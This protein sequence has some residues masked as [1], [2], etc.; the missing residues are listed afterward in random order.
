[1]AETQNEYGLPTDKAEPRRTAKLL[2]RFYRTE[3]N[4]KFVQA[5]LDQLTQS[6]TVKK[7]NGYIGR[8]NAKAVTGN[9]VFIE[10]VTTDRQHYQLEPS[11]V[12]KDTLDNVTFFK[13]Y[14]DYTNTVDV[15][16]GVNKNHEKLNNQEFY[17]WNPHVSWDKLVNFQQY[18]WLPYGPSIVNIPGQQK[19]IVSTYKVI[20]VDEEDNR[21]YLFTPN[22]LTRNP[23]LKL[24]RGQTYYFEVDSL[25]EPFSIKTQRVAG[26]LFRYTN[27]V[28]NNATGSGVVAFTVP[29]NSPDVL[30]YVSENSVDTGGVF[31]IFDITENTTI[32]V[33]ADVLKKKT[34]RLANGIELSNGMKVT[35]SGEVTP[36]SYSLGAFYVEGV[37]DEI[38]L[39]PENDL[40]IITGYSETIAILFDDG[41]FD[42][43]PFSDTSAFAGQKDYITINRSNIDGNPWSRYN[44]WFH[45]DV[46]TKSA[47][48]NGLDPV[49]DQLQ[50]A[51]RPIIEFESNLKL[52][53]FGTTNKKNV[54][55]IDNYTKDIFSTVEGSLGYIV[56]N[57]PLVQGNRVL[58]T[59]DTDSLANNRIFKVDFITVHEPGKNPVRQ[60]HLVEED[61]TDSLTNETVLIRSGTL[62]QGKTYWFN[63]TTWK[64]AQEKISINQS[65]LFD[66]FDSD[67]KSIS[68]IT[69][70]TGSTFVGNK[71]FS[72]KI[73]STGVTDPVLGFK[74]SYKN[75]N[76]IGDIVFN[77]D[78]LQNSFSY[79]DGVDVVTEKTDSKFLKVIVDRITSTFDNGWTTNLIKN[80]Q[81]VVKIYKNV[82]GSTF[83]I[84]V[85]DDIGK[86]NDLEVRVYIDGK[87]LDKSKW[88]L[89][90]GEKY[91]YIDLS[92]TLAIDTVLTIK[93]FSAQD[94][95]QKG[96]Y[97]FPINLQN[98]PLNQ[99]IDTFTLG[100]AIDHVDSIIDNTSAFVGNYPGSGNLRDLA[101]LSP[102]GTKF[103]QHSGPLNLGLYH[104]TSKN[105][106]IIKAL[107]QARNEYGKFKRNFVNLATSLESVDDVKTFVD[108]ILFE[109]NKDKS[110]STPYYFSDMIGYGASTKTD[111][112][113]V[114]Y[115]IKT[116]PLTEMFS[117]D[118]LSSKA[119]NVYVNGI[120]VL[121][122][123]DYTFN[124]SGF[125]EFTNSYALQN[126]AVITVYEYESTDGCF[127]P[128]TPTSL[129]IWPKYEPKIYLDTTLITPRQVIQG[130]DGSI[131]LAYNDYR[132]NLILDIE[133][134][135]FNNIK[136]KYN[137]EIFDILD[138]I[139]GY[140]R[141]TA[142]S[143]D[144]F[145]KILAPNFYQW[146][147][148]IDRDFTKPLTYTPENLF[149]YNYKNNQSPDG[150]SLPAYWRGIYSW[151]FDTDRIHICPWES[152]GFSIEPVWWNSVY[153]TAPYTSDNFLLWNDL[154][155]GI[156]REPN[157]PVFRN[158][159]FARPTLA[160]RSPVDENGSLINPVA[161][162]IVQG[163]VNL[164]TTNDDF[165]FGDNSPVETAW[166]RSSFY[167]FSV[168]VAATLMQPNK[169]LG[170][171]LDRSR[172]VKNKNNQL[173]YKDTGLR[174]KLNDI[175]LPS[176]PSDNARI[177]TAGLVNYIVDYILSDNLKSLNEYK[178]DLEYLNNH[179]SH[180]LGG[181]TS[182]EKLNLILDSKSPSAISGVFVPK[183]NYN[184][185]LN[186]SSPTKKLNYSG[187]I[188]TKVLT[189]S[190]VGYEV[191]GYSQTQPFFYYYPWIQPGYDINVGGISESYTVWTSGQV[192]SAGNIVQ[193][194]NIYY[195]VKSNHTAQDNFDQTLYQ[196]LAVLPTIGGRTA[197]L[198][199]TWDREPNIVSYGTTY[200]TIQEVVDF[201]QGYGEYLKDQGFVFDDYNTNLKAVASWETSVKEFLFWT[202]QNWSAGTQKYKEWNQQIELKAD[203]TV[204]FNGD[205]Y[206]SIRDHV[207]TNTFQSNL[208]NKLDGLSQDGA[209]V[210]T[211]SPA[212]LGL[213][214]NVPYNVID[215]IRDSFNEY[216]I[217][218]AD[219]LKFD[220]NF[221][222]YTRENNLFSFSPRVGGT[223]IYGA[224]LFLVQK[225]HVLILDNT[226]QFND[227]IYN[228]PAGY[229][230]D[231]IK[232]SGYKTVDW[233]G[234]FDI[235]GFI[236]D[237]AKTSSWNP[238]VDY[239][240]GDIAKYKEF[241]YSAEKFLPGVEQ[242]NSEDWIKLENKPVPELL[243]NW[244]YK[245]EQ[246]TDFY[247]LES[248][249][250]DSQQQKIAQHLIGYQKRQYLENII[251]NDVSEYKFFQGMLPEKGSVNV[252]NKL[253]DVLSANDTESI[254]FN[255]EWA[256]RVGQY[257]GSD[258][259]NEIEFTLNESLFKTN[260]QAFELV[261]VAD[262]SLVDFVIR[263]TPNE[264]YVKPNNYNN[265]PWPV[266]DN[267][268]PYLRTPGFV[269][270][271]QVLLN[272]DSLDNIIGKDI[273]TFNNGDYV[274]CAFQNRSW[275]VY[276]FTKAEFFAKDISY[277]NKVLTIE[278]DRI[279]N[280][281]VGDI[282][283]IE[284]SA[285]IQGFHKIA[286]IELSI[287]TVDIEIKDWKSAFQDSAQVLFYK[288]ASQRALSIDDDFDLPKT[289]KPNE[290]IWTDDNGAGKNAV[291]QNTPVYEK[292]TLADTSAE[293]AERFGRILATNA[294]ASVLLTSTDNN[295]VYVYKRSLVS[296][297][298]WVKSQTLANSTITGFG[299]TL[300]VSPDGEWI[301]IASPTHNSGQGVVLMYSADANGNY[302]YVSTLTSPNAGNN[303]QY[304][305]KI[306]IA[307]TS[308]GYRMIVSQPAFNSS[309]GRLYS[310][311]GT[312]TDG[313]TTAW[314]LEGAVET[315]TTV[316]DN[317]GYD[318]DITPD[319]STLIVSAPAANAYSGKV[320]VYNH[321]SSLYELTQTLTSGAS[322]PERYGE[323]VSITT[324][325]NTVAVGSILYDG[326]ET[327]QGLVRLYKLSVGT[328]TAD[329]LIKNRNPESAE[330]F[331]ARVQFINNDK[332]LVIFSTLGDSITTTT[333]DAGATLFDSG[334]TRIATINKDIGRFDVY[335][336]YNT[337]F[338]F[339]ESLPLN[340][341]STDRYGFAFTAGNNTII[342]SAP[343]ATYNGIKSGLLYTY[344]KPESEYSWKQIQIQEKVVDL[345]KI[346]KV[347]LYNKKTN[348]LVTYLDV[349]DPIQGKIAGIAEQ[350]IKFKTY[351]DPATYSVGT[352]TVNVDDG[353]AWTDNQVGML[354][355]NMTK[356]K[357]L[358]SQIGDV[359]YKN[360]TWNTL[361]DTASIDIYEWVESKLTPLEWDKQ[362]DTE[363]GITL[364]ISGTSLYGNSVYSVKKRYDTIS[365]AFKNTYYFWVKNKTIIPNVID[366]ALSARDVANL[367]SDPKSYGHKFIEFTSTN[368]FS[369]VNVN[370]L[371]QNSDVIL[372][373]QYWLV[374]SD[375]L[376]IHTEW[377]LISEHPNSTIP[378]AIE[379]KWIDSLVGVDDNNRMVPDINLPAKQKYGIQF[380]PR[381]SI[382]VNRLEA[383]KQ[384]IERLNS[385]LN[386]ILI[387]DSVDLTDFNSFEALPSKI[388]GTFDYVI[389]TYEEL[390]LINTGA[391]TTAQIVPVISNGRIVDANIITA[392][393]GY[394]HAPEI[395]I[396]GTGSGAKIR[397]TINDAGSITGII[398]DDDG[399]NYSNNAT[400]SI[401]P[402]SVLVRSDSNALNRW[403]IYAY[404]K[405]TAVWSRTKSQSYN[406]QDFWDYVDWY[407]TGYNQFS[408]IDHA[409][410]GTYQLFTLT[411]TIGQTV[412]VKN[413]GSS[414]WMLLEKYANIDSIDYTQSYKV[415]AR[416][417]GTI[418][419]SN[420]FYQFGLTSSGFD[421][422]LYD[423]DSFDNS[424]STELKIILNAVKN[425]I[426][427]DD[428]KPIYLQL[429]FASLRYALSEQTFVDWAF[430]TSF[431][432]ATHNVG[433][434]AQYRTYAND[435][436]QDF[437]KYI[438]EVKPY[439][440]KIREYVSS[441]N[442][443]DN[444]QTMITD[445]DIPSVGRGNTTQPL[446]V[447]LVNDEIQFVDSEITQYP[448]K[449]WLD[450]AGFKISTID[451]VDGGSGYI[452]KPVVNIIGN[453]TTPATARAY[454][455]N[456]KVVK[457]EVITAGSGYLKSPIIEL[458]G[459]TSING[460]QARAVAII[461]ND[462]IRSNLIKIKFDRTTQNYFITEL[463]VT[464]QFT[465]TGVKLQY[466]LKWSP[467]LNIGNT[468]ITINGQEALRDTYSITS[469]KS[470][471][472]GYTSYSGLL[473]FTS[474]PAVGDV[475]VVKYIKD[476]NYL[477]AAD[478]INF[479]YNPQTGQLG[480]DL[481]QL[482]TGID[483]GGVNIVGLDFKLS[484][485]WDVLPWFSDVW[486][487]FDPTFD[488]YIIT[489]GDSTYSYQLPYIPT[490]G[491]EINVY[492]NGT[493]IDDLY[494]G[495]YDGSTVQPNG[496]T[497][498]SDNAVMQTFIG[499][500]IHNVITL[501]N[502]TDNPALNI[503]DG[504]QVIFR[505][506]TSDGA[507]APSTLDYDTA[508]SGGN[509]I[510]TTATGLAAEDIIVDGDGFV[511]PTTSPAPE[512]V[513][514]GQITDAVAVKVFQRPTNGSANILS[515]NYI[516]DGIIKEFKLGQTPNT[517]SAVVVKVN[518]QIT[519]SFTIDY[520]FQTVNFTTAPANKSVVSI[521]SFGY[522]GTDI[523]DLDY[524]IGDG[525]S[526]EFITTAPWTETLSSLVVVSGALKNYNLFRTD[527]TYDSV[528]R[529]GIRFGAAPLS[530]QI[531]NYLISNT[532]VAQ[533]SLVAKE[534]FVTNGV[535]DTYLLTNAI[536][537]AYP[538][539]PNVVVRTGNI[540][541]SSPNYT[542]FTL[543]DNILSYTIPNYKYRNTFTIDSFKVY[544]NGFEMSI[545]I[546]YTIDL[547]T[548]TILLN[549]LSYLQGKTLVIGIIDNSDYFID[550]DSTQPAIVFATTPAA[551]QTYEITSFANHDILAIQRSELEISLDV[552]VTQ[553][554]VEYFKYNEIVGGTLE[555][556]IQAISDDYVWVIKNNILLTH[557]VDYKLEPNKTSVKLT[558]SPV[559]ND[560]LVVM[561]FANNVVQSKIG[562]MQFKDMLNRTHYK[563]LTKDKQTILI[564]DLNYYDSTITVENGS[565]LADPNRG[566][567]L[568][569]ILYINGERIEYYLKTNNTL[570]QLRRGTLGTGT[571][572]KHSAGEFV[573]D[574]G[575]SETIPYNDDVL[576]ESYLHDG[577]SNTIP[578]PYMPT[579]TVG[580]IND[581]SSV[582]KTWLRQTI[583]A[584][585]GQC[586]EI[587][588]F[589]GGWN[590]LGNWTEENT[591][592][593]GDII[594]YGSYT[595]RC[596]TAHVSSTSFA[597]DI[598]KWQFFVGNQ[599]LKKHPYKVHNVTNYHESP[600]ADI[601]FEADFSVD[602]TTAGVR[603]TNDLTA[604]TKVIV[605]K[606]IGRVWNDIGKSLTESDNKIANFLKEKTTI[607]PR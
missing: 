95:N 148:L 72:Y 333:F 485:G 429:F 269:K 551:G 63:G 362:A 174:L 600:E 582:Y 457:I 382:F 45:Q 417:K 26:E 274:W 421:G 49:L 50:R 587:D 159:K 287:A 81:P 431:V 222:N 258:A 52:F 109:H 385:K 60:I 391:S 364:G 140:N 422:P 37:G 80:V 338:L 325:G 161:S 156:I 516:A 181:F 482:M 342:T 207:T 272:I 33:E 402:L 416:Q 602:G 241:Y 289:L 370:P 19:E 261:N 121:Y 88:T 468:T 575:I 87:R 603:L 518:N 526:I 232:V 168:I 79:K 589:V 428:L 452:S 246:F 64:I 36:V 341:P 496:K 358:N 374:N 375:D 540:I 98:N 296:T 597:D 61:D 442:A 465:G 228:A 27:G 172:I 198:R 411:T 188:V 423:A 180:R 479:Y 298:G 315:V 606:K 438:A 470:T 25:Q 38:T 368:S 381:Q 472:K 505:K 297:T 83:P 303:Q 42:T 291:W 62:N 607:W 304:G 281:V 217:F 367:I 183:E 519:T 144:E 134:R 517:S 565:I 116:Y 352:D 473:T 508:L 580:S 238:W 480:K 309:Q 113:V 288:F 329:Q 293:T 522:N 12:V 349:V 192:Y 166:R 377:K 558:V 231:R 446:F 490:V 68:D 469:K 279:P 122:E 236:F 294:S 147:S 259:F 48:A 567:N 191:K 226:T 196:K 1:M 605:T 230:Q 208:Y 488:D 299:S 539:E 224:G 155:D 419:I 591:Y 458:I 125:I 157:K 73:N 554:S 10:A 392:G 425:K 78:L 102:Y 107:K 76:N 371:L 440:T 169:V 507:S 203:Q 250:F 492:V 489:V 266:K 4:K 235:P 85:Y 111:Y 399:N 211:L 577:S 145:N 408:T 573:L 310:Y 595:Y 521:T 93:C 569:G 185:F 290:L 435:N 142:Y 563:R 177:Q 262:T 252:L 77:F 412:K 601:S 387:V 90:D 251:K 343:Y 240:L 365:K 201:L 24:Y 74:L 316:G 237:Q 209:S 361:Y 114:D 475:I 305:S 397:T 58:F 460:T 268:T 118:T 190:G 455:S 326:T 212:A 184:I 407:D 532:D 345:N 271:D 561:T 92:F 28:I 69:K 6:G 243:P 437:E 476:F 110:K 538:Q 527:T 557:S 41:G 239:N 141:N 16:G 337:R 286:S 369:L 15:L 56:D 528:N 321:T 599:R 415:V 32:N 396:S 189:R 216:E 199:K 112:T 445:F 542:Y 35:F 386:S 2:P 65:P 306:K 127:I 500:G 66:L 523:L 388:T 503:N 318:F 256:L 152:L 23:T 436:L 104:L 115:R 13:D 273:T 356:A 461:K 400:L 167:P 51:T 53:N 278:F 531:I 481:S 427:I 314:T 186:T 586:D 22:G 31:Q 566:R 409:V 405:I 91:K 593:I 447:K 512:E 335:D 55:L 348:K 308:I 355:W 151:I 99:N 17:S 206:I 108:N 234:G 146:T 284:N 312:I 5:T 218:K 560:T 464:E 357:F 70:Y 520:D 336:K 44:R 165:V 40:E 390:R 260:P 311:T 254:D 572:A 3:S 434:L 456:G 372:A 547:T 487:G 462:L 478:R 331:G 84:D 590:I 29:E 546:D 136:V 499:N 194:N 295:E 178:Y 160:L 524:F 187:V 47:E 34:Y 454:I 545:M 20:T 424:G 598:T 510:Y 450:N 179:L 210:I 103:V 571:P 154:K 219:G 463:N 229:K 514:P 176:I 123:K 474:S 18:Y 430:K 394:I 213:S 248:D 506:S 556:G 498:A 153:G 170:T 379:K 100:E 378:A 578:L 173:I 263:Q 197:N 9:D 149:T 7:L 175:V 534:T 129:G 94:K 568:P 182:K 276:R 253:F 535:N 137:P 576:I 594:I 366:R 410:D 562:Y 82:T 515:N 449:N 14:I 128:A 592:S 143:L 57:V 398:I 204:L 432:K 453:A 86:L 282:I 96:Y 529:V 501:P 564:N 200:S 536:G 383:L 555:L 413:V 275:Q 420:K 376:N 339:A 202:T 581:G 334:A 267:F 579:P 119:V 504:D 537:N 552:S 380:R 495:L 395:S 130:H 584:Q 277:K 509:L 135:I 549:E 97:E 404:D 124:T 324:N 225:E 328:Y 340:N 418:E 583:P 21:A 158:K 139:P 351:Y 138:F 448:W 54:D 106:N 588:V 466:A 195:R 497:I 117:L 132:D 403:S 533:Y 359:V 247:D 513:I 443:I 245:A 126:N 301:A 221:L 150:R 360:S 389:D 257:G 393:S 544:L 471:A 265:N 317:F 486:D 249:N 604:G 242:F 164:Q 354:W 451:V 491:Q 313:S 330:A 439:R 89:R 433:Q 285:L 548:G 105:A 30:Y 71:I 559:L 43:A 332:S 215:D 75:I 585:H 406:V 477:N 223:G 441:Y 101:N 414:G 227:T 255:E 353:M 322:K 8:Q 344:I 163:F 320:Y 205:F 280:L 363:T 384:Y 162:N 401:R 67:E 133:K 596:I 426:L 327:D 373:V 11:A 494:Y 302:L 270:Y 525:S 46:I 543:A 131:V 550:T 120:Q 283:G 39:I 347:F 444:T 541:L 483:Y 502:L 59:A 307:S 214:M 459:G 220:Q 530:G 350:E 264:I 467:D 323:S 171:C 319:S 570:T 484:S 493:R 553:G 244:D 292:K 233:Y 346:K 511:T 300:A 193:Y 574:I